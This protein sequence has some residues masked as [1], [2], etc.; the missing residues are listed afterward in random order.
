MS[1]QAVLSIGRRNL[2]F[3]WACPTSLREILKQGSKRS[4]LKQIRGATRS[5]L[6]LV[7]IALLILSFAVWG[8]N[9][10][11]RG[12]LGSSV[13]QVGE[14]SISMSD[15]R[16]D[17]ELA[18]RQQGE[19][20]GR[21]PTM[22]EARDSG[23]AEAALRRLI[24]GATLEEAGRRLGLRVSDDLVREAYEGIEAFIDPLTQQFDPVRAI[25]L[26]RQNG[27]SDVDFE[28]QLRAEIIQ[29]QLNNGSVGGLRPPSILTDLRMA[30]LT[31][32]RAISFVAVTPSNVVLPT[33]VDEAELVAFFE[34][35]QENFARP[36]TRNISLVRLSLSG[37]A[38]IL[39]IPEEEL[40]ALYQQELSVLAAG[41]RR[42][43]QIFS[44]ADPSLAGPIEERLNAG[45]PFETIAA[46]VEGV[47][48]TSRESVTEI[49][50]RDRA[51]RER[52]FALG[53]GEYSEPIEGG[54]GQRIVYVSRLVE[55]ERPDR[56][57]VIADLRERL[58]EEQ[59]A[60]A[61]FA[62]LSE[63]EEARNQG[64]SLVAA[65]EQAGVPVIALAQVTPQGVSLADDSRFD[66]RAARDI[67][68]RAF[69]Q[70]VGLETE[71]VDL[72]D[73]GYF[74]L[75]VDAVDERRERSLAEV[76]D[77]VEAVYLRNARNDAVLA[78]AREIEDALKRGLSGEAFATETGGDFILGQ[79]SYSRLLPPDPA[80]DPQS[81]AR[82]FGLFEGET[83]VS[84]RGD[85]SYLV[86]RVDD[87]RAGEELP[88]VFAE[89]V[90]SQ[91]EE[92]LVQG[93]SVSMVTQM[94][95]EYEVRRDRTNFNTAL[96]LNQSATP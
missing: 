57:E 35:R 51:I 21:Q 32:E 38:S 9:D 47:T 88:P 53:V 81:A 33:Q 74:A 5:P 27:W 52:A 13:A 46:E 79:T 2:L 55:S 62:A 41:D 22:E 86:L 37:F 18:A 56:D 82:S 93:I 36:E 72:G 48:L 45:L 10:I 8:I 73:D 30:F 29:R 40:E 6:A 42:D 44:F 89:Q 64:L 50:V 71:T 92:E 94:Q 61:L 7:L 58:A 78:R 85:G 31:E 19:E 1:W 15:L 17:V 43:L 67:L 80:V 84:P 28:R 83:L 34:E 90:S 25:G 49:D 59:A 16:R 91:V 12:S 70:Q 14:T 39:E 4:M 60:D 87:I 20:T 95:N 3:H 77:E 23:I 24:A 11:F 96:G 66:D 63:F 54:V 68:D 26:L 65:A 75:Q 69:S 76:R